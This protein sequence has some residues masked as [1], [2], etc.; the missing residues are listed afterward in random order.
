MLYFWG[1]EC[2]HH[3]MSSSPTLAVENTPTPQ[4][5]PCAALD[6]T[7][8]ASPKNSAWFC[9]NDLI[10]SHI[11]KGPTTSFSVKQI[12]GWSW[13]FFGGARAARW[14]TKECFPPSLPAL[15]NCLLDSSVAW[16]T[17]N[18]TLLCVLSCFTP[19]VVFWRVNILDFDDKL[20]RYSIIRESIPRLLRS[21]EFFIKNCYVK[22]DYSESF[23]G[24]KF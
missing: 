16:P 3:Y 11:S 15:D 13:W 24:W 7:S 10:F 14:C 19:G 17:F 9:I 5:G 23:C 20:L 22:L 8:T 6:S 1:R 2:V 12:T 4:W 18:K 21:L